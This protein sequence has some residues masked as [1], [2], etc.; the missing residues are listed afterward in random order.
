[1]RIYELKSSRESIG[2]LFGWKKGNQER[3]KYSKSCKVKKEVKL[4]IY[5][6]FEISNLNVIVFKVVYL[7]CNLEYM[8]GVLSK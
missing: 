4:F 3:E 1:M 2:V 6:Y 8:I 5:I 7:K